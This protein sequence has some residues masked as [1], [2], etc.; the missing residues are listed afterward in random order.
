MA[1]LLLPVLLLAIM[2]FFLIVPQKKKQK[3]QADLMSSIGPGDEVITSGG[4]YGGVT[5]VDGDSVYLEI[6]PDIEIKIA[7][8]AIADRVYSATRPAPV[9]AA[10]P[11]SGLAGRLAARFGVGPSK[12]AVRSEAVLV[13]DES[14][15]GAEAEVVDE[16][17]Q[18]KI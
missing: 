17:D 5:E 13:E 18:G 3:A 10:A 9:S 11:P 2:Y 6:A 16:A 15:E 4:I 8:R 14:V 1:N 12:A 7:R